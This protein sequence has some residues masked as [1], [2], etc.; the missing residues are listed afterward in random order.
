[1]ISRSAGGIGRAIFLALLFLVFGTRL[2]SPA[3]FMPAFAGGAMTIVVCPDSG[4][5]AAPAAHHH[6]GGSKKLHQTCPYA[7]GTA[8]AT[9]IDNLAPLAAVLVFGAALSLGRRNRFP[10]RRRAHD[11]PPLRGPPL[12]A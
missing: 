11:R 5:G 3:G 4:G 12:P 9:L 2:L 1:V 6:H 7:A 10:V 8:A